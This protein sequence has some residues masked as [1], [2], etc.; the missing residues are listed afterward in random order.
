MEQPLP[1]SRRPRCPEIERKVSGLGAKVAAERA[2]RGWSLAQL[3]QR[4]G[5]SPGAVH[6]IEKSGMT[7]TIASLMKIAAALGRS[8]SYFVEEPAT[9]DVSVIRRDE[10]APVYTSKHGL[11]LQNISGR[12]G[13]FLIAGAE[14]VMEPYADSGPTP[15]NHPGE[16]LVIVTGG[17]DASSRSTAGATTSRPATRSTS[18]RC[19]RTPGRNPHR[20]AG[21]RDLARRPLLL[22]CLWLEGVRDLLDAVLDGVADAIYL[23]GPRGEVRLIN[24]AGLAVLGYDR[25][26][27]LLGRDSHA[28]IHHT[29]PD[30]TPF[31]AEQ[32]PLLQA[33]TSG[34]HGARRAGLVRPP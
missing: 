6:K 25:A 28:T 19:S 9:P 12:Y 27:E 30:G 4:A 18:A 3:A 21:P 29:R 1:T 20:A 32:C 8:V 23:V 11:D 13:P 31:P 7:P 16:E 10:R 2:E 34:R 33:R 24:P 17:R 22:T 14:A 26:D 5:M 15:M